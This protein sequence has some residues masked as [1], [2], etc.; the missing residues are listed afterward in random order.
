MRSL[1]VSG[2]LCCR[3]TLLVQVQFAVYQ[4]LWTLPTAVLLKQL[5]S[6]CVAARGSRDLSFPG[7]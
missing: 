6:G 7:V 4:N 3:D 1:H 2:C 5:C